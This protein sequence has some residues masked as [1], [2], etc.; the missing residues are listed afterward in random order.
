SDNCLACHG[1]D[2]NKRKA[3]LRLDTAEG[4]T[5]VHKGHQAVKPGDLQAS[6]VW[7]RINATDPKVVM[8]PPDSHKHLTAAQIALLC[9][10]IEQGATY[11]KHWAFV[12]PVRPEPP[13]VKKTNWPRNDIDRFIL[14]TLEAKGLEPMPEASKETLVRRA[15]LDLTG[16][17]PTPQE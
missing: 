10:W 4:L 3:D 2:N 7:R 14:A 15:T 9:R 8:P 12:A 13:P 16:L 6:E 17:P 11:Q 5:A 1:F